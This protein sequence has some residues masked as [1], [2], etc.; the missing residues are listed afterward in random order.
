MLRFDGTLK[1][2]SG[3]AAWTTATTRFLVFAS[4]SID[5]ASCADGL[6]RITLHLSRTTDDLDQIMRL[7]K[8]ECGGSE[9]LLTIGYMQVQLSEWVVG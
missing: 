9:E 4:L 1:G 7:S 5:V 6:C 3:R 8:G 2:P